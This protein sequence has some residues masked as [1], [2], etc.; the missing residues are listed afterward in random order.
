M[1]LMI[2]LAK[3]I[4][5]RRLAGEEERPRR[6]RP[7]RIAT[8]PVVEDDDVEHVQQLPLVLVNPLHLA[9]EERVWI[10]GLTARPLKPVDEPPLCLTL[11]IGE[12][13]A[14]R[15]VTRQGRKPAQLRQ[16]A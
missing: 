14:E 1:S 12:P 8:H 6:D 15:G 3:L 11:R 5:R 16:I 7:V 4:G 2:S 13:L 10:G 9:V